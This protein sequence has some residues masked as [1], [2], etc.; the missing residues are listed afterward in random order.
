KMPLSDGKYPLLKKFS[1]NWDHLDKSIREFK[2]H[3][4]LEVYFKNIL[5][6]SADFSKSVKVQLDEILSLLV[7]NFD[8]E[9]LPL[10]QQIRLNELIIQMD[11]DKYAAQDLLDAEKYIFDE[12]V[13]FLQ[14]LSNAAFNP[15][16]SGATKITQALA[17]S[18]SQPW[19]VE[20]HDAF[21]ANSRNNL[22]SSIEL[23]IDGFN[24]STHNGTDENEQIQQHEYYW[25]SILE[26][27]LNR[28]SFP[29]GSLLIGVLVCL[30]AFWSFGYHAIAGII[31][32]GIG[33]ALIW[34]AINNYKKA[35][36]QIKQNI[37]ERETKSKEVL[38]GCIAET[39]DYRA[40]SS[41]EDAKA[42]LLR[43]LLM[44]I[45]PEDFSSVSKD[46]KNILQLN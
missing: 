25:K 5:S 33:G 28:L 30:V 21:T 39:V 2:I 15:D 13:D 40:E 27:E 6:Y 45:R 10:Q 20:A 43:Q 23:V 7:T 24:T 34:N 16:L 9:E 17:V 41:G 8:D 36:R 18:I 1:T 26:T 46:T 12:K 38:R 3:A 4:I 42:E 31:C 14:L 44:E 37:E 11:G 35:K 29:A 32:V 19:I 22:P